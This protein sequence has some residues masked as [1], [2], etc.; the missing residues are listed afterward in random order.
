MQP[1]GEPVPLLDLSGEFSELEAEWFAAIREIGRSG[2][3]I[4]GP[5]VIAFEQE[6]AAYVGSAHAVS[7]ASGTDALTLSLRALEIGPGDEV[8]T[9]P[10][11][12]FSTAEAI[13]HVG[14]TPVFADVSADSFNID[15]ESIRARITPRTRALIPVHLFGHPADMGE[16]MSLAHEHDLHVIEDCAQA[17]G[18]NVGMQRVGSI[19]MTGCF[20]FYPTKVLGCYGD[21]G[22]ITTNS[23][24]IADRL[25]R[26]RNH[27][28]VRAFIHTEV[29]QNSRLDE[30][31]AALLRLKLRSVDHAI[32]RRR[33]LA[34]MY[35]ERFDGFPVT[36]PALPRQAGHVFNLYTIQ[37]AQRDAVRDRLTAAGIASSICYPQPLHLQPVYGEL[38]H[39]PGDLPVAET[40]AREVLSLPIYP[41]M[42]EGQ[43][44][45]VCATIKAAL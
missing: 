4:V 34:A 9:T 35:T 22:M 12:F 37:L 5:N 29:G 31:Q 13:N 44:D 30:I 18:A 32:L 11:T 36:V 27:G 15:P 23:A 33:E 38:G 45:R 39:Q 41:D 10:F 20:S 26:L 16:I 43:V 21:G 24:E 14:A 2:R 7:V 6:L 17:F 1:V 3:F 19:G 8:V 28:A 40:L 25:R 42:T